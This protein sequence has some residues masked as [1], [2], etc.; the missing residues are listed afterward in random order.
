[1]YTCIIC[2]HT[3][4]LDDTV[5]VGVLRQCV[6]RRCDDR[7]MGSGQLSAATPSAGGDQ[8]HASAPH[9]EKVGSGRR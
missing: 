4:A 5:I 7:I 2:N 3:T 6:C 8:R 9:R 1:M